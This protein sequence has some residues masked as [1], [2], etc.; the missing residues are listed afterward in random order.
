MVAKMESIA[1]VALGL[2]ASARAC[3][4]QRLLESLETPSAADIEM[5]WASEVDDRVK[6]FDAGKLKSVPARQVFRRLKARSV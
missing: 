4:A 2:P 3:L 6:A 1:K 5:A